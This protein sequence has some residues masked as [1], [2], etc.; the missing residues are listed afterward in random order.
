MSAVPQRLAFRNRGKKCT[1]FLRLLPQKAWHACCHATLVTRHW[2][3][4]RKASFTCFIDKEAAIQGG[5]EPQRMARTVHPRRASRGQQWEGLWGVAS[6]CGP[7]IARRSSQAQ[8]PASRRSR[9]SMHL[10]S[11]FFLHPLPRP[12]LPGF[13]CNRSPPGSRRAP[14]DDPHQQP[15]GQDGGLCAEARLPCV[16][17]RF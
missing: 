12:R 9:I 17:T 10:A 2:S 11:S 5:Y 3:P 4:G 14:E 16:C 1:H 6:P 8:F 13:P 7:G 15:R